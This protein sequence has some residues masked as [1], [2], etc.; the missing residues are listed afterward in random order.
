MAKAET[1]LIAI[2]YRYFLAVA[3]TGSV[4]AASRSLNVAASAISRQLILLEE[5]LGV[6]LFDRSG[7]GL[8]LSPAGLILLQGLRVAAQGHEKTMDELSALKGLKRG[9]LR[10]ATVESI[11]VSIL[12]DMLLDFASR[13][14]GIEV[15]VTVAGSDAVTAIVRD[16]QAD[17]GFTFNPTSLEGLEAVASSDLHLGAI[18]APAHPLAKAQ[19][20]SLAD[21]ADFPLAWPSP[22]LSL[23]AILDS[24]PAARRIR[25]AFECNSLRL[26]ASLARRGSCIAFQTPI[27]IEQ[28]L[29]L[30]ELA[31]IPLSDKRL[32]LDRLKVVARQGAG[33][34]PAL[35]AFL[36]I[37]RH[38]LPQN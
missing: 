37:A 19:R 9:L 12:P 24:A 33:G 2:G 21:C 14:Q 20:L 38:H 8:T 18:M 3:E 4:R 23:R 25:P 16:H 30:G 26:M 32:P 6:S 15:A 34:R 29:A 17:L 28:E 35:D 11:S 36:A 1:A 22:G 7:R 10:I 13:Y 27:G 5:S 31:W